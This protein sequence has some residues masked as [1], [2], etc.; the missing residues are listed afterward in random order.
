MDWTRSS[1]RRWAERLAVLEFYTLA[2][3]G[4][5]PP[6]INLLELWVFGNQDHLSQ[7]EMLDC[8][9]L[10]VQAVPHCWKYV[11]FRSI[12]LE[13]KDRLHGT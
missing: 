2:S 13:L 9:G 3:K 7:L 11:A 10:Y 8:C 4:V 12:G 5:H 6:R 1:A